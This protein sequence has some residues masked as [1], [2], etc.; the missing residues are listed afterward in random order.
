MN[1]V[2]HL[3]RLILFLILMLYLLLPSHALAIHQVESVMATMI[4]SDPDCRYYIY[5]IHIIVNLHNEWFVWYTSGV[6]LEEYVIETQ[7]DPNTNSPYHWWRTVEV[8]QHVGV[9]PG[10]ILNVMVIPYYGGTVYGTAEYTLAQ[11]PSEPPQNCEC[12]L[13]MN[14]SPNEVSPQ[15]A[16]SANTAS[17]IRVSTTKP[18]P[19]EGCTV[20]FKVEPVENSGGHSHGGNR[21]KG[22]VTPTTLTI[23][24]GSLEPVYALY[25]SSDVSGQEKIIV[26]VNGSKADEKMVEVKVPDLMPLDSLSWYNLTGSTSSHSANH[27]GTNS[28]KVAVYNMASDYWNEALVRLGINDMSLPWG[29][30]FDINGNWSSSPGHSLHRTGESVDIDRCADGVLVDQELLDKIA[31]R[32]DGERTVEDALKPPPCAG[33]ADTPRIHYDFSE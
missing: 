20:N 31:L 15:K 24:A 1:T 7:L 30:L 2:R 12:E 25:S 27:Y 33:P 9:Q 22:T 4:G 11:A 32:Y 18:A 3:K 5:E 26:E 8:T 10:R 13:S 6:V 29:G 28:T 19:P 21:P 23:P 14:V 17:T 16:G